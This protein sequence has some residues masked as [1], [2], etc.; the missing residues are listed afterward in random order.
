MASDGTTPSALTL[1]TGH[2]AGREV[3]QQTVRDAFAC[4][5]REGW[6]ELIVSDASFEDWPLRERAVVE[7]LQAWSKTG[8][9]FVMLAQNYKA[10]Q[11]DQPRFVTWRQTWS[12]I[13]ECR[14]CRTVDPLDFPSAI[15][16]PAWVMRRLDL[17]R[18]TGAAGTEPDR[19]V[20]LRELLDE[21]LR[22]SA[23]GFPSSVLGL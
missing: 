3:F 18:C 7:S 6:P 19:R 21:H 23:A 16:S 11:R 5:A 17:Q 9:R 2:F 22:S 14:V 4:A 10:L 15:W 12:H 1:P 13:I 20:I 8:R